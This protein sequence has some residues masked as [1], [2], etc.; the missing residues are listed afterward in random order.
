MTRA[1]RAQ[2]RPVAGTAPTRDDPGM[3][4]S[5]PLG[6]LACPRCDRTPLPRDENGFRCAGCRV[7][8]PLV[9]GIPWLFAEPGAALGEWRARLHLSLRELERRRAELEDTL[10][11]PKLRASTRRRLEVLR[12]A[13]ADHATRLAALLAPL[14]L[15]APAASRE[16]YLALRTRLPP[17]QGLM[18]YFGNVHRDW[19]WGREENEASLELVADALGSVPAG[20][21]LVLGAGAGRLA[22]DIHQRLGSEST[23]ALDF[24]P[25]LLFV[26]DRVSRGES[27]E[28]YEFPLAPRRLQDQAVLQRLAAEEPA[29]PGLACVLADVHRPP[30]AAKSFDT[31]VTPWL[32]DILPEPLDTLAARINA[33]LADGGRWVNF[34]SLSFHDA[35]PALRYSLEECA[36]V[37]TENGFSEP[38]VTESEIPYLSGPASRHH[39]REQVVVWAAE[40]TLSVKP[41]ARHEALPD[42]IVRGNAPVPLLGAFQSQAMATRIHA[43]IM[44]LIDGRRSL[45]DMARMLAQQKLMTVEEAEPT[46]RSFLIK[47]YEDSRRQTAY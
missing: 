45:K 31:V 18:T 16:T 41:P 2:A 4:E 32:V 22:Y 15:E 47:M 3:T 33:L 39:R 38:R 24:N 20:R 5:E 21:T 46:L 40:K 29:K 28:L 23:V 11:N 13:T 25:L 34:G 35:E 42:W 14:G 1:T 37:V 36:E 10:R 12:D 44:S 6:Q 7:D 27:L 43:Y 8:F 19:A 26:A 17:D 9:G 30:F